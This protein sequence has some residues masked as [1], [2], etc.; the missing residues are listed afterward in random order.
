MMTAL[1][2]ADLTGLGILAE[3]SLTNPSGV[4]NASFISVP[5]SVS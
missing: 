5:P 1:K 3:L 4:L 2:N